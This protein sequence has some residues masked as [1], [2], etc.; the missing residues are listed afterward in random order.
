VH[1]AECYSELTKWWVNQGPE[2][3]TRTQQREAPTD[4][5]GRG[6]KRGLGHSDCNAH[7]SPD[8]LDGNSFLSDNSADRRSRPFEPEGNM[9]DDMGSKEVIKV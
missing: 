8:Q 3:L 9:G 4:P 6:G 5:Q 7:T 1:T 2:R